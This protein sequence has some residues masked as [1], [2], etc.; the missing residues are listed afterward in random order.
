M[1][2]RLLP[3][4]LIARTD[5]EGRCGSQSGVPN[6]RLI[7]TACQWV[8]IEFE[9]AGT[10]LRGFFFCKGGT[11]KVGG[12]SP[13]SPGPSPIAVFQLTPSFPKRKRSRS[14]TNTPA[15]SPRFDA[16]NVQ[17]MLI[18]VTRNSTVF[19]MPCH[20]RLC[21]GRCLTLPKMNWKS[22]RLQDQ[23]SPVLSYHCV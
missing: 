10:P 11:A 15:P 19:C 14:V 5:G 1:A 21:R 23:S 16:L 18:C 20:L 3:A 13:S 22:Q 2:T 17:L 9:V 4:L 7:N 8:V 12:H 6:T